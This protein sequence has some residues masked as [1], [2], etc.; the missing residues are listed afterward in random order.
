[1]SPEQ[2]NI[3]MSLLERL[4]NRS[5]TLTDAA[6]WPVLIVV[7]TALVGLICFMWLDLR[8]VVKDNKIEAKKDIETLW[9]ALRTCQNNGCPNGRNGRE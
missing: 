4:A 3:F 9:N 8:S 1:M 6:D 7:G 5:Y 2:F